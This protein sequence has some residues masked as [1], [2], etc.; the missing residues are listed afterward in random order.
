MGII[1]IIIIFG[2]GIAIGMYFSSQI[3][4]HIDKNIKKDE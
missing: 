1:G 3:D 2:V 4:G